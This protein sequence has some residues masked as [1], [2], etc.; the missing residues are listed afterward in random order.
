MVSASFSSNYSGNSRV[1]EFAFNVRV[2]LA[3]EKRHARITRSTR[4]S[5]GISANFYV[6]FDSS[7]K[8]ARGT[9][10][11]RSPPREKDRSDCTA[12]LIISRIPDVTQLRFT[13]AK[14]RN[15]RSCA[16]TRTYWYVLDCSIS[17][18]DIRER[19]TYAHTS[20]VWRHRLPAAPI[21][22]WSI[23]EDRKRGYILLSIIFPRRYGR[24]DL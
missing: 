5:K 12:T 14:Q 19:L 8:Y 16:S 10:F 23:S 3:H 4:S 15:L 13:V 24:E 11:Y 2:K 9:T 6:A 22:S 20:T 18:A 7:R 21:T 17:F 1:C